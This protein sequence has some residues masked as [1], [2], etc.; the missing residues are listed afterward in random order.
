DPADVHSDS[1][2]IEYILQILNVYFPSA[3]VTKADLV[4]SY[5]G[6]RP[7]V[8]DSGATESATSREHVII[9]DPRNVTFVAGGKYTTYR[10][11]GEQTVDAALTAFSLED[12]VRFGRNDTKKPLIPEASPSNLQRARLLAP[13]WAEQSWFTE[14]ETATL[15]E[16]H[17][18]EAERMIHEALRLKIK[19]VWEVEARFAIQNTM[20]IGLDDFFIRRVPLFLVR[21]DHGLSEAESISKTFA[22][23]LG[24]NESERQSGLEAIQKHIRH[25]LSWQTRLA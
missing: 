23:L 14:A 22:S 20:C 7:L 25:E 21:R 2:D 8:A 17:G 13:R 15:A 3:N 18:M 5:S 10:H 16:R 4:S 11:M 19:N 1:R 6:V 12:R 9:S 24:W